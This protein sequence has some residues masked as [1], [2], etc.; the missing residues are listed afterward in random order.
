MDSQWTAKLL[1]Q[2]ISSVFVIWFFWY[3]CVWIHSFFQYFVFYSFLGIYT[4]SFYN[5]NIWIF[6]FLKFL[7]CTVYKH[8]QEIYQWND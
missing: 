1:K 3:F 8:V 7:Q 2:L 5:I 6:E 4:A